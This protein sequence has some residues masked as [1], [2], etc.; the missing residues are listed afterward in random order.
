VTTP[1]FNRLAG[2]TAQAMTHAFNLAKAGTVHGRFACTAPGCRGE[3]EFSASR[4]QPH[5]HAGSCK[6]PGCIRWAQQ[7]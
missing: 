1:R 4:A 3:I 7:P 5:R 2:P 6:S